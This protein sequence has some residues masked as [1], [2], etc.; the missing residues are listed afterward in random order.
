MAPLLQKVGSLKFFLTRRQG[1]PLPVGSLKL[2]AP[3]PSDDDIKH[4]KEHLEVL[5]RDLLEPE[6]TSS[7]PK[8]WRK[9]V[10]ELLYDTEDRLDKVTLLPGGDFSELI[11]GVEDA[12][13]RRERLKQAL[14]DKIIKP[15]L[16]E[17][18]VSS[19]LTPDQLTSHKLSMPTS[20]GS[21]CIVG[22]DEL[23]NKLV[24]QL[25]FDD[26]NRKG[27]KVVPIL[28]F[29]GTI[30]VNSNLMFLSSFSFSCL[31]FLLLVGL[32]GVGKTTAAGTLYHQHRGKFQ[33]SA[34]V[35]VSRTP[36]MRSLLISIL[37]QI[38]AP[39]PWDFPDVHNLIDGIKEHLK[40]KRYVCQLHKQMI[41]CRL[42]YFHSYI[43]LLFQIMS[44]CLF[45]CN[46]EKPKQLIIYNGGSI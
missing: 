20:A 19:C 13:E 39:L 24:K 10:R 9:E 30:Y 4:F 12:C 22:V 31:L 29:P 23:M 27:L 16:G 7:M 6:E 15:D 21:S 8:W 42:I 11:A 44:F 41:C 3:C 46:L 18:R 40:G 37:S 25:A 32:A 43:L 35:R 26:L 36:D 28:G 14:N 45:V 33:C 17:V 1:R 5:C 34:F 38:K 2:I